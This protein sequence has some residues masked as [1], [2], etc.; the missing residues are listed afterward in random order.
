MFEG[1]AKKKRCR[2]CRQAAARD[3]YARHNQ[4][5]G[6]NPFKN[7]VTKYRATKKEK[8]LDAYGKSCACCGEAQVLFLTIDHVNND[9]AAHRSKI[10]NGSSNLYTWLIKNGFPER[11]QVLCSNCNLGKHLNGGVCPHV[12]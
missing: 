4:N 10:G 7:K 12:G 2:P 1:T 9:G 3:R 11:F 8:V 5:G 6:P